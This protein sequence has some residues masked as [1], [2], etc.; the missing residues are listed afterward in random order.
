M[1]FDKDKY[2]SWAR[3]E[4]M[5]EH[6]AAFLAEQMDISSVNPNDLSALENK[7]RDEFNAS[8]HD[9]RSEID[10]RAMLARVQVDDLK[11]D[12]SQMEARVEGNLKTGLLALQRALLTSSAFNALTTLSA[13]TFLAFWWG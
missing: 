12:F 3:A 1:G 8:I 13:V 7:L 2:I 4:G 5:E 6:Q 11:A 9:L 10:Q